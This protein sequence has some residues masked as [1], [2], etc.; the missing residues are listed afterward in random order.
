MFLD[1]VFTHT[2]II[3]EFQSTFNKEDIDGYYVSLLANGTIFQTQV[4]PITSVLNKDII[5]PAH[6]KSVTRQH[7]NPKD[8]FVNYLKE[9]DNVNQL[10]LSQKPKHTNSK[11]QSFPPLDTISLW[12]LTCS[13]VS[14]VLVNGVQHSAYSYD[15]YNHILTI[16]S[17]GLDLTVP[18][19]IVFT[20]I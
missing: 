9:F 17:L 20:P 18:F 2:H 13:S 16:N 11:L 3:N 10:L 14:Q 7:N 1:P 15:S 4:I 19:L 12:G 6:T 5:P 8:K